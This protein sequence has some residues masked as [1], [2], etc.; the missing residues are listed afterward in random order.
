MQALD[1]AM[2]RIFSS[3]FSV[4]LLSHPHLPLPSMP[5]LTWTFPGETHFQPR[6]LYHFTARITRFFLLLCLHSSLNLSFAIPLLM[7]FLPWASSRLCLSPLHHFPSLVPSCL[8]SSCWAPCQRKKNCKK[9]PGTSWDQGIL[10]CGPSAAVRRLEKV[11]NLEECTS[12]WIGG[13]R[14]HLSQGCIKLR[15]RCLWERWKDIE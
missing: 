14:E 7:S 12:R 11:T 10:L 8:L 1:E 6:A 3:L 15:S 2:I 9:H 13:G 4:F 5:H